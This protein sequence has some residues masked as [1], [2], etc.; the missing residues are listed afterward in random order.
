M[1]DAWI[2]ISIYLAYHSVVG[3]PQK[4]SVGPENE[5]LIH[6][7]PLC[8]KTLIFV[9]HSDVVISQSP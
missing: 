9:N 2:S 7:S 1:L 6:I 3:E 8:N 4:V 5:K